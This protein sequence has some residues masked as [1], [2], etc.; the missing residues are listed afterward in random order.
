MEILDSSVQEIGGIE[1]SKP[2][3]TGSIVLKDKN[4]YLLKIHQNLFLINFSA[5]KFIAS[6]NSCIF[7]GDKNTYLLILYPLV[8]IKSDDL[9]N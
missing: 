5:L 3:E 4:D 9:Y 8:K 7:I 2:I 1:Y 6:K